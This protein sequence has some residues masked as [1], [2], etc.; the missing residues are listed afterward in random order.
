VDYFTDVPPRVGQTTCVRCRTHFVRGSRIYA[1]KIVAGV[2]KHPR[3][4]GSAVYVSD[5]EEFSH[6][7][8][9]DARLNDPFIELAR[10]RLVMTSDIKPIHARVPDHTCALCKKQFRREDRIVMAVIVEGI[11]RDPDTKNKAVQCS[12]EYE[13]AHVDCHDPTLQGGL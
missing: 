2:G 4:F 8:C 11:V 10:N 12:G 1:V 6:V 9:T 3:G 5:F 13:M 7:K